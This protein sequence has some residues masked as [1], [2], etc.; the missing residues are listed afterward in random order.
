MISYPLKP[1][2]HFIQTIAL[3]RGRMG[4]TAYN[5]IQIVWIS[6][7]PEEPVS[8]IALFFP[9]LITVLNWSR[10]GDSDVLSFYKILHN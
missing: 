9:S 6:E 4:V 1:F 10:S 2:V 3:F 7:S 5:Q 8:K